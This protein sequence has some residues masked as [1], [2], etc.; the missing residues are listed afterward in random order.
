[1]DART[2]EA[3]DDDQR[4]QPCV[5]SPA[6]SPCGGPATWDRHP[7]GALAGDD[8]DVTDRVNVHTRHRTVPEGD[9]RLSQVAGRGH[10][11]IAVLHERLK[12]LYLR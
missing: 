6:S 9:E 4:E 1:M 12:D 7:C 5:M 8:E 3:S 2:P 10:G 11:D